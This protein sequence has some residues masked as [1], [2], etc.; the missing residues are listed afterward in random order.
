[1]SN[2]NEQFNENMTLDEVEAK[3]EELNQLRVRIIQREVDK[4]KVI[5]HIKVQMMTYGIT[6]EDLKPFET[7]EIKEEVKSKDYE[8]RATVLQGYQLRCPDG[9]FACLDHQRII[10]AKHC[11]AVILPG[12]SA[13]FTAEKFTCTITKADG[14]GT[15]EITIIVMPHLVHT[16]VLSLNTKLYLHPNQDY[17]FVAL[18]PH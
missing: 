5:E 8:L 2:S 3:I 6:I 13:Q 16:F 14:P 18:R 4:K 9:Q 17:Q 15:K 7:K 11:G 12:H 10:S 1:M